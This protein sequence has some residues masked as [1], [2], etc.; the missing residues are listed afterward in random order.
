MAAITGSLSRTSCRTPA[1]RV[2]AAHSSHTTTSTPTNAGHPT[3][4]IVTT[5]T[6]RNHLTRQG[7]HPGTSLRLHGGPHLWPLRRAGRPNFTST[8]D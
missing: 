5:T 8:A 3:D 6:A 1:A 7:Y 2:P 4:T